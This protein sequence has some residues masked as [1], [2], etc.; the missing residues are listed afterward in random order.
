ME[1][2]VKAL[3]DRLAHLDRMMDTVKD[4]MAHNYETLT[5]TSQHK[6]SVTF[7]LE[8]PENPTF[9]NQGENQSEELITAEIHQN[10]R[11]TE[12]SQPPP[13]LPEKSRKKN[14]SAGISIPLTLRPRLRKSKKQN[15]T[16]YL[17]MKAISAPKKPP[18]LESIPETSQVLKPLLAE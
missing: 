16:G 15:M 10:P 1:M 7:M 9:S 12:A 6:K 11:G 8:D 17:E 13:P 4:N 3:D 5:P 18:R 14:K 2:T